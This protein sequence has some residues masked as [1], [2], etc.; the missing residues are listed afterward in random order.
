MEKF[1]PIEDAVLGR[2]R[3]RDCIDITSVIQDDRNSLT[4]TGELN[5]MLAQN[6]RRRV[7][8]PYRL[9]FHGVLAYFACELDTYENMDRGAH[10]AGSG[11]VLVENRAW[12][13]ALPIREDYD[14][15]RYKHY[16]VFTYDAAY[17]IIAVSYDLTCDLSCAKERED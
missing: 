3:G 9:R 11:F 2:L 17:N 6:V 15:S 5:G 12:K 10:C 8:L 1:V 4:F 16:Q 7:W 14:R 13:D